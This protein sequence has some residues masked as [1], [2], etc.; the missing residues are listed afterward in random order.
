MQCTPPPSRRGGW[1]LKKDFGGE[2]MWWTYVAVV[3]FTWK[4]NMKIEPKWRLNNW[5]SYDLTKD[6]KHA[7]VRLFCDNGAEFCIMIME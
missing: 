5:L 7:I 6:A 1:K 3:R 2:C 4:F